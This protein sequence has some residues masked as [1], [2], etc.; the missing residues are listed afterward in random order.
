MELFDEENIH[1]ALADQ[2]ENYGTLNGIEDERRESHADSEVERDELLR[3]VFT[4]INHVLT[5][6]ESDILCS[7]Y[8][9]QAKRQSVEHLALKYGVTAKKIR[10]ILNDAEEKLRYSD[11]AIEIWKYLYRK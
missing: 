1:T 2:W 11:D 3:H 9:L 4:M 6:Q 8:G 5:T 10:S 7:Y